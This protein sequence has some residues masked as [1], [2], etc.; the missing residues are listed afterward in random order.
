MG[1][2]DVI[3][4]YI[5]I[6]HKRNILF[7]LFCSTATFVPLIIADLMYDVNLNDMLLSFLPFVMSGICVIFASL[8]TVRFKKM[9]KMQERLYHVQFQDEDVVHLDLII[10]LSKEWFISAGTCAIYKPHIKSISYKR[11]SNSTYVIIKTLDDKKY[12]MFCKSTT[13]VNKI[14]KWKNSNNAKV[15]MI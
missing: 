12:K 15:E 13:N 8:W 2:N 10:Y 7:A 14:R 9:I 11:I 5:K 4:K 3:N 6:Y 1:K